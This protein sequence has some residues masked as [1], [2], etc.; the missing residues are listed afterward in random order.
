[1]FLTPAV[2]LISL[3][4]SSSGEG[5]VASVFEMW[6]G[7]RVAATM[8]DPQHA[9]GS[10]DPLK[11]A[12]GDRRRQH[13]RTV[14]V[15]VRA[16]ARPNGVS[17][18]VSDAPGTWSKPQSPSACGTQATICVRGPVQPSDGLDQLPV[19]QRTRDARIQNSAG[20]AGAVKRPVVPHALSGKE[21]TRRP[22]S[23]GAG[24]NAGR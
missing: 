5:R 12:G 8:P 3:Q 7:M 18:S 23:P 17:V 4:P 22:A 1:M 13:G 15:H 20:A 19:C 21:G 16:T 6:S 9:C 11:G 2:G 10:V 24:Q 14:Q